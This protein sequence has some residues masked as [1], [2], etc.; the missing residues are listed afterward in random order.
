MDELLLAKQDADLLIT[1]LELLRQRTRDSKTLAVQFSI[2][3]LI[4]RLE[5]LHG[6]ERLHAL[7]AIQRALSEIEVELEANSSDTG[8]VG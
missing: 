8:E 6:D 5:K 3:S 7:A 1:A 4:E 2:Q